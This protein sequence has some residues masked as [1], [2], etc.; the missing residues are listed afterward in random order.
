MET[1]LSAKAPPSNGRV[2]LFIKNLLPI[3][4]CSFV[5]CFEI[6]TQQRLYTLQ[7]YAFIYVQVSQVGSSFMFADQDYITPIFTRHDNFPFLSL[8][9]MLFENEGLGKAFGQ[10]V[11]EVY[12]NYYGNEEANR[13]II[14]RNLLDSTFNTL[15][16]FIRRWEIR[17]YC[18]M[19]AESR[20]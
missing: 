15:Q 2:F 12:Y 7:Y 17:T 8:S 3:N 19:T 6:A 1:Y 13:Y 16:V 11:T 9:L 4:E 14:I 10:M 5:V 18:D 20:N